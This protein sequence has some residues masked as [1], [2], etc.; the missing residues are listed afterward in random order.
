[1]KLMD[2][3]GEIARL[4]AIAR[5]AAQKGWGHYAERLG[6]GKELPDG[7]PAPRTSDAVRLREAFEELGPTF[8]KLGQMI[9]GRADL[10]PAALVAE[11]SRLHEKARPF[12]AETARRIIEEETGRALG[13]LYASFEDQPM[14]AASIAQVHRATRHDGTA[15][16]VKVQRPGI[17]GTVEADMS[18]LRRIAGML[19]SAVPAVRPFTLPEVVEETAQTLR[20]ELDFRRE[21]HNAER[22][23]QANHNE[24]AVY[25]PR[26]FWDATTARVLTMEYSPGRRLD[27]LALPAGGNSELAQLLIRVFLEHVFEHGVFHGDPHPGNV[28]LLADGR[29]CFHDFG[30]LGE[31]SP[32]LQESLRELFLAVVARDATWA[33]SAY[34]GMGGA[35][36]EVERGAFATDLGAALDRYYRESGL[37]RE[38]F[39]AI[40]QEFVRLGRRHRIQLLR[41]TALLLRAF[42]ELEGLVRGLDPK[43]D[44]LVAF[45][46]YSSRLLKHAFVPD[47]GVGNVAQLYRFGSAAR[48]VAGDAPV[49]LRRLIGRL[50]RG[51]PLFDIRHQSGGSLER[52]LLHASNRLAFALIIAAMVVGSAIIIAAD[53]GPH[54]SGVP[55]LG[56]LGFGVSAVLGAAWGVLALTS[57]KL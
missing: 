50:E 55:V 17:A 14:A 3:H 34:L 54:I 16:I 10:F 56:V 18:V 24:P 28:F 22:F 9:A 38:S 37:G 26:I 32:R 5:V 47:I 30:A 45:R 40:L 31:V 51:E 11:L 53:A 35:S 20:G 19:H 8:I 7:T 21:A 46:A 15:V 57:G 43:L 2:G 6:F 4:A 39:S 41:E 36:G 25:V 29:I 13:E 23:A 1:M 27:T 52:H 33:A 49:A 44:P 48:E 12:P 42:A